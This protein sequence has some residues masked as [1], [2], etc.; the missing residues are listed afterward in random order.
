MSHAQADTHTH[1]LSLFLSKKALRQ[2]NAPSPARSCIY[3][4]L[5][6]IGSPA[7]EMDVR[8]VRTACARNMWTLRKPACMRVCLRELRVGRAGLS[9]FFFLSPLQSLVSRESLVSPRRERERERE[10]SE[11]N[12]F[13]LARPLN[14]SLAHF[15]PVAGCFFFRAHTAGAVRERRRRE[16]LGRVTLSPRIH[17]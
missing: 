13:L 3:A 2:F 6:G 12:T 14:R 8:L 15:L 7:M 1:T 17:I 4:Y 16:G 10:N 9:F 11:T 5:P